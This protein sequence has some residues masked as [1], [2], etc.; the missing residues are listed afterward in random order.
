MT[1]AEGVALMRSWC[2]HN[3]RDQ[4]GVKWEPYSTGERIANAWLFALREGRSGQLPADLVSAFAEM[5]HVLGGRLEY[6]GA[7]PVSNHVV[8]NARALLCAAAV[9]DNHSYAEVAVAILDDAL[10]VL[11]RDGF[12]AEGSSHY[13]CLFTRWLLDITAVARSAHLDRLVEHLEPVALSLLRRCRFFAVK[14]PGTGRATMALFGDV[15]PDCSPEWLM[16]VLAE[17]ARHLPAAAEAGAG[18]MPVDWKRCDRDGLTVIARTERRPPFENQGHRH[19]DVGGFVLY[20]HGWPIFVDVGRLSYRTGAGAALDAYGASALAH[21]TIIV[22]RLEPTV[23]ASLSRMPFAYRNYALDSRIEESAERTTLAI[24]HNGFNRSADRHLMHTRR[25]SL[26]AGACVIEDQLA[27]STSHSV[28]TR[29]HLAPGATATPISGRP[30]AFNLTWPG[31]A[32]AGLLTYSS[33]G[34]DS[35]GPAITIRAGHA[36]PGEPA[37]WYFPKYG[38]SVPA[39]TLI[40]RDRA[41]GR[42]AST[43][44]LTFG[45]R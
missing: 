28:E 33:N 5:A 40:I 37:G 25:I 38:E 21:N 32:R 27:G 7:S 44:V 11:V 13:H 30:A 12:L 42:V 39:S 8:N 23:P 36:D 22:D 15:S 1:W 20:Q 19:G 10:P 16:R 26:G 29:L 17:Y 35:A 3:L 31:G 2:W 6:N 41:T 43:C 9:C 4:S 34:T 24:T 14:D 45:D 18:E